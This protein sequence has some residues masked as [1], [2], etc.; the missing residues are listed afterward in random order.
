MSAA[1]VSVKDGTAAAA[2]NIT[3]GA[4]TRVTPGS[5]VTVALQSTT[6]IRR[7]IL[8][9]DG[10]NQLPGGSPN[11][12]SIGKGFVYQCNLGGPFS[13]TFLLPNF[14]ALVPLISSTWDG[15]VNVKARIVLDARVM[16]KTAPVHLVRGVV[17]TNQTVS[18]FASVSGGSIADGVTYV[19]GDRVLL[20]GQTAT[21][22]NGIYVVGAVTGGSAPLTRAP[23]MFTGDV[24]P[25]G[26]IVEVSEG[27]VQQNSTWKCMTS[28][29][30]TV[31]TTNVQYFPRV[32]RGATALVGGSFIIT[33]PIY[34][35]TLST[36]VLTRST[37]NTASATSGGYATNA[38]TTG[39]GAT[40]TANVIA[41]VVAGTINA[42]D[43]S[44]L[45][46]SVINW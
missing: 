30:N 43:V 45:N 38:M 17:Q 16:S 31:G 1:S 41:C 14:D 20:A 37:A 24:I 36:V 21:S 33:A 2:V 26:Q 15:N 25:S 22:A 34:S 23:D 35:T 40:G 46:W 32:T 29:S 13:V 3:D 7:W 11:N 44:T 39:L 18:Q 28:G 9:E 27:T 4:T 5:L 6:G 42:A 12:N 10:S 19:Q 8:S